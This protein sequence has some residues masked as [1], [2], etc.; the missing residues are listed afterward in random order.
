MAIESSPTSSAQVSRA[1]RLGPYASG[2]EAQEPGL[3]FIWR[4]HGP[5]RRSSSWRDLQAVDFTS[6]LCLGCPL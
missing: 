1:A 4:P 2:L 3:A 6:L 5:A